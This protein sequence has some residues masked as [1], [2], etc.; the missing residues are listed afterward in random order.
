MIW[1]WVLLAW[2]PAR[3]L[4]GFAD[5]LQQRGAWYHAI[6]EYR[7]Q[8]FFGVG[9]SLEALQGIARAYE[10]RGKRVWALRAWG[11]VNYRAPSPE[12]RHHMARL[13]L[14]QERPREALALLFGDTSRTGRAL[15]AVA[16]GLEGAYPAARDSLQRLGLK[17]PALP[18][19]TLLAVV[20]WGLPGLGFLLLGEP[21]QGLSSLAAQ[22][23]SVA[24][25]GW[26]LRRRAYADAASV[27]LTFT[28]RFYVGGRASLRR[29]YRERTRR[30]LLQ[31][32]HRLPQA[33]P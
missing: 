6:T 32:L 13:L 25:A 1:L 22:I 27:A 15:R 30:F 16:R 23:G 29:L 8:L 14:E 26:L 28:L 12:V 9:D 4:P 10:A 18:S 33:E 7:R 5:S 24:W 21:I 31:V 3:P 20:S 17:V 2:N 11:E 19:P